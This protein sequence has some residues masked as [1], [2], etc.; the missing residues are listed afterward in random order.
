MPYLIHAVKQLHY[1]PGFY[2]KLDTDDLLRILT[3]ENPMALVMPQ[4]LMG[5]QKSW[6]SLH[7]RNS[8]YYL[9]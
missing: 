2:P 6:E 1:D 3:V 8:R 4:L 7:S 5:R 9:Q